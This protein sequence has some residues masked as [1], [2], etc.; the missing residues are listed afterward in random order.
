M[1]AAENWHLELW[2]RNLTDEFYINGGFDTRTVWG[3]DFTVIGQ[4]RELGVTLGF[5]F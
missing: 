3:Y 4:R 5:V 1:P 2:G